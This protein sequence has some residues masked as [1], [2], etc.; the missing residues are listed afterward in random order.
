MT[1]FIIV[2]VS[3]AGNENHTH[4]VRMTALTST[5]KAMGNAEDF[6]GLR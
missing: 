3:T 1:E 4:P 5:H 6:S 2:D